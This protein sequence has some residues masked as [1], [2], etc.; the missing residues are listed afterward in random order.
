MRLCKLAD[1]GR[2]TGVVLLEQRIHNVVDWGQ[3][4]G[5]RADHVPSVVQKFKSHWNKSV[6]FFVFFVFFFFSKFIFILSHIATYFLYFR[7]IHGL[8]YNALKLF[9]E[10]NQT[11]FDE[12]TQ[13]YKQMKE[14]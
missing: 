5:G 4:A 2:R 10:M 1:L 7:T 9:M 3:R 11:L 8:I 6:L 14:R 13:K 12:C